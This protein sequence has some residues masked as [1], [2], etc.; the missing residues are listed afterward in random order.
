MEALEE[1]DDLD[2]DEEVPSVRFLG[3]GFELLLSCSEDHIYYLLG[4]LLGGDG[5]EKGAK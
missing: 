3:L 2:E 4:L 1:R 5:E